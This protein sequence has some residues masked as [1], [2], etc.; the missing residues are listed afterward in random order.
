MRRGYFHPPPTISHQLNMDECQYIHPREV[1]LPLPYETG[2]VQE[3][4]NPHQLDEQSKKHHPFGP[5]QAN[6][7]IDNFHPQS[8]PQCTCV[9]PNACVL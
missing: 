2:K 5:H 9:P 7:F 4:L 6:D 8:N 3:T 1:T